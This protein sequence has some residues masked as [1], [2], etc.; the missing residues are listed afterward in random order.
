MQLDT[1]KIEDDRLLK[2]FEAKHK[3]FCDRASQQIFEV[4]DLS[5]FREQSKVAAISLAQLDEEE[6]RVRQELEDDVRDSFVEA[7]R[8]G[9]PI[10]ILL[11]DRM[12]LDGGGVE[13]SKRILHDEITSGEMKSGFK[14]LEEAIPHR[15]NL[16]LE[17]LVSR[18]KYQ[19]LFTDNEVNFC[20]N[21]MRNYN[22]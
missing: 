4:A 16:S 14:K 21:L 10:S 18:P 8:I 12:K 7:H 22:L 11:I 5:Q 3:Y 1:G 19:R 20:K 9:I 13:F 15:V 17:Y 6:I 2:Q